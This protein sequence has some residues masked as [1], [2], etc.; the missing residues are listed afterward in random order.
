MSDLSFSISTNDRCVKTHRQGVLQQIYQSSSKVCDNAL[1]RKAF[2]MDAVRTSLQRLMDETGERPKP[3]AAKLCLSQNGIRDVF[4]EKTKSVSGP[5]LTAIAQY[6]NVAV[7]DLLAG[8]ATTQ[9]RVANIAEEKPA[10]SADILAPILAQCLRLSPPDGWSEADAMLLAQS[11]EYGLRFLSSA[12]SK[13]ASAD[14]LSVAGRTAAFRL[15]EL[16]SQA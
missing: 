16:R 8:T 1:M 12:D 2:P 10:V 11:V 13:L 14:D 4:L 15:Q 6:F 3:L 7:D 5:K 9:N